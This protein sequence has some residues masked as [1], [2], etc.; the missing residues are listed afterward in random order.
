MSQRRW[1]A[2]E[3]IALIALIII[4]SCAKV[5]A[6]PGGP[7]D[8]SGPEIISTIPAGDAVSVA[9]VNSIS[10]EFSESIEKKTIEDAVFISPRIEGE[11]EYK[12]KKHTLNI[13]LP[14]AFEDST[15]YIVSLG[16]DITDIRR[17]KMENSYNFAFST[18]TH[19]DY[20][21][22][23]GTVFKDG[24][25]ASGA[26][27][28]LYDFAAPDSLTVFDSLYPPYITQTGKTGEYTLE[29]LPDGRYYVM[30]FDDK[31]KNRLFNFPTESFGIPDRL[32]N[33]SAE[34][35]P[36]LDFN[37]VKHDTGLV[38][39]LS[40]TV[41]EDRLVKVRFSGNV[42]Y[43]TIHD[44]L[45]K[46]TL[47]ALDSTS[48]DQY[49]SAIKEY[50][51][52]THQS[53]NFYFRSLAAGRYRIK[54]DASIFERADDSTKFIAGS[55]LTITDD[56]DETAPVIDD[57]SHARKTIYPD[58]SS[59]TLH[60]SEPIDEGQITDSAVVIMDTDSNY[61]ELVH[62]RPDPFTL[63]LYA[64]GLE[65]G[66]SFEIKIAETQFFDMAGNALGDSVVNY[67]FATYDHDSLGSISGD[68]SFGPRIDSTGTP[69]LILST[70][71]GVEVLSKAMYDKSFNFE[72][73]PGKYLMSGYL[74]RNDNG[75]RDFGSL[76]PFEYSETSTFLRDTVRVR[77]RF[78][79][80]GIQFI[81]E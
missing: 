32:C 58:D 17:N 9:P 47:E 76:F 28:A 51:D 52:K 31:N 15:T 49:P 59:I 57:V 36:R 7:E 56:T 30:S 79:T 16:A 66:R 13:I 40:T 37:L 69:H 6:P 25:P 3:P 42:E 19:I 50:E 34:S 39:I 33:I 75:V 14:D 72:L 10:I 44:N 62:R 53:Y 81:F 21:K 18:G 55:E 61:I 11:I 73:P 5:S 24:K 1:I 12:W 74:D 35:T 80:S 20:G 48:V 71:K 4:L 41:T 22:V 77:A 23:T 43:E 2:F 70:T 64:A 45:D 67:R 27:V 65:W 60:F 26:V 29:F 38:S 8:K 68:I 63:D 46:V 54:I 78:E